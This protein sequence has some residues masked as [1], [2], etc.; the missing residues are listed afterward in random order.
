MKHLLT[1]SLAAFA[2]TAASQAPAPVPAATGYLQP[3]AFDILAVLPP[4]PRRGDARWKADRAIFK[5]TRRLRGT[6][7]WALATGD[8]DYSMPALMRD[9]SCAAGL[10]LSPDRMPRLAALVAR[11][12]ADTGTSSRIGKDYYKRPRPYQIDHGPICQ[13]AEELKGSYDYP[14]GHTTLGWTWATVLAELMPDRATPI[15]ARG[16]QYGESRIVCGVHNQSAVEGGRLTAAATLAAVRGLPQFQADLA[17][18][19]AELS[20]AR[21]AGGAPD[22]AQCRAEMA[23]LASPVP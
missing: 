11:A 4:A 12:A 8:V 7:R 23:T 6:A 10:R 19:A 17:A 1:A 9:F 15:L 18:A 22:E 5:Q 16:R 3:G 21:Q 20:A 13:P 2:T 14:S